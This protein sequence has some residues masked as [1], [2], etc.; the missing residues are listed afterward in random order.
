[1]EIDYEKLFQKIKKQSIMI[2]YTEAE[3]PLSLG[4]S[5][6]GGKPY[7]PADFVWPWYEGNGFDD[8]I[9]NRPLSFLAQFN[10]EEITE[11]DTDHQLPEKGML[12]F[13]Y[14]LETMKW[15]FDPKDKG[16]ARV[17]YNE[18]I[19]NLQP[20]D[21][22]SELGQDWIVPEFKMEFQGRTS[23]PD[24]E[25]AENFLVGLDWDQYEEERQMFL[26]DAEISDEGESKLLG[27]ADTIQGAMLMECEQVT[28]G[29][30]CG[31]MPP[32][33]TEQQQEILRKDSMEWTLL[34]QMSDLEGEDFELIF[35]DCGSIYFY[36]RKSELEQKNF[37][38]VWM[39]LQ[40]F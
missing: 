18:N 26:T 39:V 23:L 30:Y 12:Y 8:E 19:E 10:L 22:P 35:G 13:F 34:F 25:E 21:P 20:M 33:V 6:F 31:G 17:F 4:S 5:K 15:G 27:Y 1:M 36:I 3:K 38:N 28:Q 40:C 37:D 9:K 7:V 2:H 11:Y 24:Y 16:S 14:D 29:I 32:K